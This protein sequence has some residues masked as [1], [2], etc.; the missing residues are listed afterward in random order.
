MI[1]KGLGISPELPVSAF[2]DTL[3][4]TG[5][6]LGGKE[7][8]KAVNTQKVTSLRPKHIKLG[9]L[10]CFIIPGCSKI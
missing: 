8:E 2:Q 7:L 9:G 10:E 4:L 1:H 6:Y 5:R 3:F